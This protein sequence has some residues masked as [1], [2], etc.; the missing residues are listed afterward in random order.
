MATVDGNIRSH[1]GNARI[2]DVGRN[3][4]SQIYDEELPTATTGLAVAGDEVRAKNVKTA[5]KPKFSSF[6]RYVFLH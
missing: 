2:I 1:V 5:S 3:S 6:H 4:D